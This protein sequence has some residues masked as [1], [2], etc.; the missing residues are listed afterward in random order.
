MSSDLNPTPSPEPTETPAEVVASPD[1]EAASEQLKE[2]DG[3]WQSLPPRDPETGKFVKKDESVAETPEAVE[4]PSAEEPAPEVTEEAAEEPVEEVPVEDAKPTVVLKG[5]AER[6]EEDIELAVD[7]PAIA[8]RLQRLQ[9]DG[10]RKKEYEVLR[11]EV[12]AQ[13]AEI[14]EWNTA[15]EHN[16]IGTVI[17]SIPKAAGLDVAKALVAEYWDDL[18]PVLQQMSQDP[19]NIY[20][21]RLESR[22]VAAQADR[23]A[24]QVT[25]ASRR[26]EQILDATAKLVPETV[27]PNIKRMFLE[28]AERDLVRLAQSGVAVSP[29]TVAQQ[30]Q[31]RIQMYG[32][33]KSP[34]QP[35]KPAVAKRVGTTGPSTAA[36]DVEKAKQVQARI[37]ATAQTR[38]A[39]AAIPPAGRGPVAT[40]K[41]LVPKGADIEAASDAL[42]KAD[43]WAAF[44]PT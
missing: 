17:Q 22:E 9:N 10:I 37:Q 28:D 8:E 11:A 1:I 13:K 32:F 34:V 38:K 2:M 40:R 15:M 5:L 27:A 3:S 25:D 29:E 18:F 24:R 33:G 20:K 42:S 23:Q 44:R 16:P 30:L 19:S 12:N 36:P 39:A 41:T 4:E 31:D 21:T 35:A 26:A 7:D 14:A 43:S 6:G